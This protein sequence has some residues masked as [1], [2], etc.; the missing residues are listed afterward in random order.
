MVLT[1]IPPVTI[2]LGLDLG[3]KRDPTAFVAVEVEYPPEDGRQDDMH[4]VVHGLE[5]YPLGTPYPDI[6]RRVKTRYEQ[7]G[8][9]AWAQA[10][11]SV[12]ES[13]PEILQRQ[14]AEAKK[15]GKMLWEP[16]AA[17]L[18]ALKQRLFQPPRITL[19]VDAT[20]VGQPI[21]DLL[22]AEGIPTIGCTFTH[23]D[24]LTWH[25]DRLIVGKALLVARLQTLFQTD[26]IHLPKSSEAEAMRQELLDFDTIIDEK[27]NDRY[28]AF[29]VGSH[30]DLVTALGL[31]TLPPPP[32]R[33][34]IAM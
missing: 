22:Q 26:R 28:G 4:F 30:D 1:L 21:V 3:Q 34:W 9:R 24:L 8:I 32:P 12:E 18:Q 31:A 29:K 5:R 33:R 27:A 6:V 19:F 16:T 2:Q 14:T 17:E 10:E 20:G 13:L 15:D 11:R 25:P 23:G 7:I